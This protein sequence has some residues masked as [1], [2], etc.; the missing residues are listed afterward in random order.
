M[1]LF[2]LNT[3]IAYN[4]QHPSV[5]TCFGPFLDHLQANILY[6]LLEN[7]GLKMI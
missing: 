7:T 1:V 5:A 4:Q 6:L 2:R 3:M